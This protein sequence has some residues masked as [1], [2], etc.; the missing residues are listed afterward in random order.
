MGI[1]VIASNTSIKVNGAVSATST[2]TGATLYTAPA[3]GYA[4]VQ[5]SA[6]SVA[7]GALTF[8]IASRELVK[9]QTDGSGGTYFGG[10]YNNS[11]TG[12]DS[13]LTNIFIGPSQALSFTAISS[14]TVNVTGVEFINSP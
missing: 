13:C 9:A 5:I 11:G 8:S 1:G 2:S 7:G 4:I 10:Q 14:S 12:V 3:N 6:V